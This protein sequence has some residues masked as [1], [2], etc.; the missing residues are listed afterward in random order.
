MFLVYFITLL[1][2]MTL[3][4]VVLRRKNE[5]KSFYITLLVY[6]VVIISFIVYRAID[7]YR[8][9]KKD[10]EFEGYKLDPNAIV[11]T[12]VCNTTNLK[13]YQILLDGLGG[14]DT[15][16]TVTSIGECNLIKDY[17]SNIYL[18]Y[19]VKSAGIDNIYLLTKSSDNVFGITNIKGGGDPI[20]YSDIKNTERQR[21]CSMGGVCNYRERDSFMFKAAQDETYFYDFLNYDEITDTVVYYRSV[22]VKLSTNQCISSIFI[23]EKSGSASGGCKETYPSDYD[24]GETPE[25]FNNIITTP[26]PVIR[27]ID[28]DIIYYGSESLTCYGIIY[29]IEL[30]IK[31]EGMCR[32]IKILNANIDRFGFGISEF[33]P[34]IYRYDKLKEEIYAEVNQFTEY[35]GLTVQDISKNVL[36]SSIENV[37][38]ENR[39]KYRKTILGMMRTDIKSIFGNIIDG[40]NV[41]EIVFIHGQNKKP[42]IMRTIVKIFNIENEPYNYY[43][44]GSGYTLSYIKPILFNN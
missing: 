2:M 20:L 15:I 29:I 26:D 7:T 27:G 36:E 18:R 33:L 28:Q 31:K 39:E 24:I 13:G 41:N 5:N 4:L 40:K 22:N 37:E 44:V 12:L 19:I 35:I 14:T 34:F 23:L 1:F 43:F 9:N 11:P 3:F 10:Y 21:A 16:K 17:V 38:E 42:I 25:C 30:I 8:Y 32:A 6:I